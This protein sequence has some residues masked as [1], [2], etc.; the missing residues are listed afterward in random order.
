MN[1]PSAT[2]GPGA[3]ASTPPSA[4]PAQPS[5]GQRPGA[6]R[7]NWVLF[8]NFYR[9]EITNRYLGS[10]VGLLWALVHPIALLVVY[11]FVFTTIYQARGF[12]NQSFLL[13]V[14]VALWPWLATQ[15]GLQR[16]T[17]SLAGYGGLI[18][19]VA[20]PHE[21]VV[22]AS[23]LATFTLQFVGYILV[24]AILALV[25][26]P[27]RFQ[28]LLVAI[29]VWIVLAIAT[30]GVSLCLSALQVFIRDIEHVL[31]PVM[32][33][34]M[35]L[36]PILYPL[37]LVPARLQPWVAANPFAWLVE[38]LRQSLLDGMLAFTWADPLALA[39]ALL[40]FAGGLWVFRRLSP[41]FEDF[42]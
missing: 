3:M 21:L 35:Y 11:E 6:A 1:A 32:M 8:S 34:L 27:V 33:I 10:G 14:A 41:T 4:T 26:E 23:V 25:G 24:L 36:A 17:V 5:P 20:F 31:M 18:R 28:G 39:A 37:S 19:R 40:V 22:Y 2:Q 30:I 42:V 12:G 38:R 15:E 29:P 9:R 13:F 7:R 16:A